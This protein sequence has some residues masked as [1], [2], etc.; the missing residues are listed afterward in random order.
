M[1]SILLPLKLI[2]LKVG[3]FSKEL[4]WII[5]KSLFWQLNDAKLVSGVKIL[6]G[7][8]EIKLL[9]RVK[10]FKLGRFWNHS[11]LRFLI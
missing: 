3:M 11:G 5:V 8:L 7:K 1:A 2:F 4:P 9:D 10:P 6:F